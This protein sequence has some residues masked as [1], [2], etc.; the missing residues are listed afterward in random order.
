MNVKL[1]F[2]GEH[3]LAV[4]CWGAHFMNVKLL[5]TGEHTL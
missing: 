4:V 1:L 5:F 2:T 3:T